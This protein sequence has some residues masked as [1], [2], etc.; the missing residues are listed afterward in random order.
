MN[1]NMLFMKRSTRRVVWFIAGDSN[2]NETGLY[3]LFSIKFQVLHHCI[4]VTRMQFP[5]HFAF[6]G[7]VR[8]GL[9]RTLK[10]LV[11]DYYLSF[12]FP[13]PLYVDLLQV[14]KFKDLFL[15]HKQSDRLCNPSAVQNMPSTHANFVLKEPVLFAASNY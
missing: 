1:R 7:T 12:F 3:S 11:V 10:F 9:R 2:G 4:E 14:E 8:N 5:Y 13:R 6:A 15:L